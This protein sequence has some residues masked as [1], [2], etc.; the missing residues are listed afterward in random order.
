MSNNCNFASGHSRHLVVVSKPGFL[1]VADHLRPFSGASKASEGNEQ[2]RGAVGGQ[3]RLQGVYLRHLRDKILVSNP[4]F[5]VTWNPL[6]PQIEFKLS[7]P[8]LIWKSMS[9]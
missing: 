1:G 2:G 7:L 3:G 8:S 5:W 9:T 4:I 6:G